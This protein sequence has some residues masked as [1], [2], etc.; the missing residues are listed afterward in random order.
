MFSFPSEHPAQPHTIIT[1]K[2]NKMDPISLAWSCKQLPQLLTIM[3]TSSAPPAAPP[4]RSIVVTTRVHQEY[5]EAQK[6]NG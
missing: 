5:E 3:D 2:P 1:N 6:R 4:F